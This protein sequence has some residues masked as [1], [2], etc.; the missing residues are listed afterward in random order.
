MAE[1]QEKKAK[2][3][4]STHAD[5]ASRQW[6]RTARNVEKRRRKHAQRH[7][8]DSEALGNWDQHPVERG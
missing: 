6:A 5:K 1:K 4:K 8:N 7:P 3:N 2:S